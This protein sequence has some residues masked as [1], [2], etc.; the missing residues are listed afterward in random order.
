MNDFYKDLDNL[1]S[2]LNKRLSI[3]SKS[4]I[5]LEFFLDAC[6]SFIYGTII[7]NFF[8]NLNRDCI[9]ELNLPRGKI[10]KIKYKYRKIQKEAK[11]AISMSLKGKKIEEDYYNRFKL[12]VKNHFPKFIKIFDE[13]ESEIK[14]KKLRKYLKKKNSYIKNSQKKKKDLSTHILTKALEEYIKSNKDL[15]DNK[16]LNTLFKTISKDVIPKFSQI[17]TKDL[18][19]DKKIFLNQQ[20]KFTK[21]F[22]NRLLKKWQE[23]L[24]LFECLIQI[25]LESG[26][27]NKKKLDKTK[28]KTNNFKYEAITKIHARAIHISNEI[29][30]LLK[31]GFA[32]GANARWRSLHELSVI[33]FF[34]NDNNNEVSK[35]YLEHSIIRSLKEGRDYKSY[36]RKLGYAPLNRKEFSALKKKSK[37]LCDKYNDKFQKDYGWVP[38]AKLKERNFR[39]LEKAVKLDKLRPFYNLACDSHHGGSKGFYRIGLED[40]L[41]Q[42]I[43]LVGPSNYGLVD[44]LQNTAISLLHITSC[45]LTLVPDFES[46]IQINVMNNFVEEICK[47]A[48]EIQNEL[49]KEDYISIT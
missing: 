2:D 48:V 42:E 11:L 49:E 36:Y 9:K 39:A 4:D 31:S 29:A 43:L 7:N 23:P 28:N 47:K 44:P 8:L 32:D 3:Y 13:I 41:Q 45:L 14:I 15:P 35:R 24:D 16:D 26:E 25:S 20:R 22:E 37:A 27:K 10:E 46:I 30:S 33:S 34:L 18:I 38:S 6:H 19:K 21:K 12:N 40:H 17:L 1:F 5:L